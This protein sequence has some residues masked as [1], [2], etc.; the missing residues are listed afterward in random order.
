MVRLSVS[1][2]AGRFALTKPYC[3]GLGSWAVASAIQVPCTRVWIVDSRP[4]A[5]NTSAE[6]V[7]SGS[8][9]SRPS[10]RVRPEGTPVSQL[11][12]SPLTAATAP[13]PARLQNGRR[14]AAE[15]LPTF[16]GRTAMSGPGVTRVMWITCRRWRPVRR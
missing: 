10:S 13:D 7:A 15:R 6:R 2:S 3:F 9:T 14:Q 8:V 5:E 16:V 4:V 12:K 1:R 11:K